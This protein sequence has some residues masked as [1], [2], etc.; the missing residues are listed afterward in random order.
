MTTNDDDSIVVSRK[1]LEQV[2]RLLG[3]VENALAWL[4]PWA[5][6]DP[7]RTAGFAEV[8]T[9]LAMQ[10]AFNATSDMFDPIADKHGISSPTR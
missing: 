4:H 6:H 9:Y 5:A 2:D 7:V 10:D 1:F 8:E 3:R